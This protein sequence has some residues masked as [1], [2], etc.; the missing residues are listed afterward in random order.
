MFQVILTRG[1]AAAGRGFRTLV[2]PDEDAAKRLALAVTARAERQG[3]LLGAEVYAPS[4]ELVYE[5]G[6]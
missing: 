5:C 4:G 6:W 3:S 2:A 1:F